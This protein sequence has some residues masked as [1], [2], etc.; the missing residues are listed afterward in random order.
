MCPLG[1]L[2]QLQ[3]DKRVLNV[4]CSRHGRTDGSRGS[5]VCLDSG[6]RTAFIGHRSTTLPPQPK[7]RTGNGHQKLFPEGPR[8]SAEA[9]ST[10]RLGL[11]TITMSLQTHR[12]EEHRWE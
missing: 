6:G 9:Y 1:V 11:V 2:R 3:L 4:W 12:H 7:G 5:S 8:E 10:S